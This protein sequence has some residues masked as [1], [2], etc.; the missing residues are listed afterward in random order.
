[1]DERSKSDG[2]AGR[3]DVSC[4]LLPDLSRSLPNDLGAVV[5]TEGSDID[6][7]MG[8]LQNLGT[9]FLIQVVCAAVWIRVVIVGI[10]AAIAIPRFVG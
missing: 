4:L 1:M 9:A 2:A 6:H 10:V 5:E 7:L 3:S 8:A